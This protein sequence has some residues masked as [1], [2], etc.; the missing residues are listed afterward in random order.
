MKEGRIYLTHNMHIT[1][2]HIRT[3]TNKEWEHD[4]EIVDQRKTKTQQA[5]Y[6]NL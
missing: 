4:K 1:L 6:Q 5:K 2:T 3:H